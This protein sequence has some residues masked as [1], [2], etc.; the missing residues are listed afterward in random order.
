MNLIKGDIVKDRDGNVWLVTKVH[1]IRWQGISDWRYD[2][3][4]L[5]SSDKSWVNN[6]VVKPP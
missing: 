6:N 2:G 3:V 1:E 5:G 4:G